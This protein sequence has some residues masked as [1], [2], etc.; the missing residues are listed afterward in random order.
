MEFVLLRTR[1][2]SILAVAG[3]VGATLT[4]AGC[5]G[6]DG[7]GASVAAAPPASPGA[8]A[9]PPT[10][11]GSSSGS[12]R[13]PTILGSPRSSV[14]QGTAYTFT[15]NA[16]DPD[17]NALT[18][19]VTNKPAWAA[20]NSSTGQLSGTPTAADIGATSNIVISV[21]D[22][23]MSAS[24]ASFSIQ[25][26]ATAAG[27]ATLTWNPPTQNTDGTALNDLAGYKVYWGTTEGNYTNSVTLNNPG[28]SSYV[29]EQLTLGTWHFVLTA[30]NSA[31]VE[32]ARSNVGSKRIL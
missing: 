3:L 23:A 10:P 29:V 25:V 12:N 18:F 9:A 21:S 32:S 15:P 31:G 19:T 22:G 2:F 24:L 16:A 6:D 8:A 28:L 4:L 30:V 13:A 1:A 11:P 26:V 20:F 14:M 7:E 5:G 17:G 27:S